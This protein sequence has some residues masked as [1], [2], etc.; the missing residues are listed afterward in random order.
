MYEEKG[1]VRYSEID[2]EGKLTIPGDIVQKGQNSN[3][4]NVVVQSLCDMGY[5]KKIASDA[6]QSLG[7]AMKMDD[8]FEKLSQ[9]EKEDALFKKAL[10]EL[11]N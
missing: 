11:A 2:S 3:C 10:I 4:W 8:A 9:Q 7:N 1:K 6:V 5:D